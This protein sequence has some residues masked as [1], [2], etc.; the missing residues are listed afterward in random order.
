MKLSALTILYKNLSTTLGEE[1]ILI[2]S[3]RSPE[4]FDLNLTS[5]EPFDV[6]ENGYSFSF[7]GMH[8][9]F[10]RSHIG[11]LVGSYYF[12][13][14]TFSILSL[15]SYAIHPDSV[16]GRNGLLVTLDLIFVN[17]Y[18]SVKG[19]STRGYSFIEV[20][21][22]GMQVP[23]F[24]GIIEYAVLLMFKRFELTDGCFNRL[25]KKIDIW[26]FVISSL[27]IVIFVTAYWV[28]QGYVTMSVV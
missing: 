5:I 10:Y 28:R 21:M 23:I 13:T 8:M 18:N 26:T 4:P 12:P 17:I 15:M 9:E 20:W 11:C 22:V 2:D 7:T 1:G 6:S 27:Y 3:T 16:A 14:F 25:S 24:L 19:P